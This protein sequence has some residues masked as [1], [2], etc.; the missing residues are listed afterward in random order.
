MTQQDLNNAIIFINRIIASNN[1]KVAIS[2]LKK[3]GYKS[4]Y[5]I[6]SADQIEKALMDLYVS[7][8]MEYADAIREIGYKEDITNWTTSPDTKE[9]IKALANQFG[10]DTSIAK[11]SLSD[12]WQQIKNGITSTTTAI[13]GGSTTTTKP[14]VPAWVILLI[15]LLGISAMIFVAVRYKKVTA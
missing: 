10:I 12:L 9:R 15:A 14:A 11:F 7:S 13:G 6:I 4:Q 1:P 3:Y 5:D 2:T 8:P